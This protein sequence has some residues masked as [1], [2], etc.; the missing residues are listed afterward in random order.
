MH[1]SIQDHRNDSCGRAGLPRRHAIRL[2]HYWRSL[3]WAHHDS[4]DIDLLARGL[5]REIA[6]PRAASRFL[7]TEAGRAALAENMTR[8]RGARARHAEVVA[9]VARHLATTGR[10]VFT[11]LAMR[12]AREGRWRVCRPD[13]FSV[14]RGLRADHL[15]PRVH[16]IKVRRADLLSELRADK[17]A[18]YRELADECYLVLAEGIA[19]PEEIPTDYG[20]VVWR[21]EQGYTLARAAPRTPCR[22]ATRHWMAMAQATPVICDDASPQMDL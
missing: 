21:A 15:A 20:V 1:D 12:T 14:T 17:T 22:L 16:E 8:H 13:V 3:G 18:R 2:R 10:V 4:I 9:G 11:E 19:E 7:L 6:D 5:I